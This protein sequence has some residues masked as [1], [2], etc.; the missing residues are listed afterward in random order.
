MI[1]IIFQYIFSY[2]NYLKAQAYGLATP[3]LTCTPLYMAYTL[4]YL[5]YVYNAHF[6]F[7]NLPLKWRCALYTEPFVF[8]LGN[9]HNNTKSVKSNIS[10]FYAT[11]RNKSRQKVCLALY[12]TSVHVRQWH[13]SCN[14]F[15]IT[16][17]DLLYFLQYFDDKVNSMKN[18]PLGFVEVRSTHLCF[19]FLNKCGK[20]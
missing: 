11:K 15:M 9:L 7:T 6:F 16:T 4:P 3:L 19:G 1:K 5:P 17:E 14:L 8:M 10:Q 13:Q 18:F 2:Q 12:S 20:I